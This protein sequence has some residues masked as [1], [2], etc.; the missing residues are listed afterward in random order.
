MWK[1]FYSKGTYNWIDV[2]DE[3]T[4]NYNNTKH[5]SILMKSKDVNKTNE[6]M[7]WITLY[8]SPMGNLPLPKFRI[9]DTVRVSK[10]KS[11][12]AKGYEANFTEEIFKVKKVL[13]GDPT[14]YEL[15]DHEGEP[16]IGKFYEEELS[17]VNKKDDTYRIEKILKK[18]KNMALVKWLGY[19]SRS[20][21]PLEDIKDIKYKMPFSKFSRDY[22]G[23][24]YGK[25][26]RNY[27]NGVAVERSKFQRKYPRADISKFEFDADLTKTGDLLRTFTRYR[28]EAGEL[29][30]IT[31]YLFEK[32]YENLLYWTPKI[33]D[34]TGTFQPFALASDSLSYNVRKFK[35]YV[36]GRTGFTSNFDALKTSWKG[37]ANDITKVP[38]DK[39][40]PYFA[41]LLAALIISHV[42]GI[43]RKHL[44][45]DNKVIT[46]IARYYIYYH[47][48]RFTENPTKMS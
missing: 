12:F 32:N 2:L 36:N 8:G 5:G 29:F 14:I 25:A 27:R 6:N 40:D 7:V 33:W 44:N 42:G 3:L 20:W 47:M 48:K 1:Y 19:D 34:V 13:R 37:T 38:I 15:E 45:G 31:G 26:E 39:D 17:S 21:V 46:S 18:K 35:I 4:K 16:I 11:V 28:N 30:E 43:S 10:Y 22:F 9:G 41:S 24:N 23:S